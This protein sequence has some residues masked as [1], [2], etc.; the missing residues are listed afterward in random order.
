[1]KRVL[2]LLFLLFVAPNVRAAGSDVLTRLMQEP[3]TLFDWGLAQLDRDIRQVARET[4]VDRLGLGTPAAD[5]RFDRGRRK[6]VLG[7]TMALPPASRSK[8]TCTR[9]FHEIVAGLTRAAPQ[10]TT[11]A[12]WYLQNAFQPERRVTTNRFEG[13]GANLLKVVQLHV[14]LIPTPS[15][16]FKDDK[17]LVSCHGQLDAQQ[18]EI[19]VEEAP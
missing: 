14:V 4:F 2:P 5:A 1:M 18:G 8:A 19:T 16:V 9:A 6:V 3:L 7:A 11:A 13:V 17:R 15:D 10:R 12:A